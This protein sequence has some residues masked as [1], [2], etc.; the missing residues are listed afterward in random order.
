MKQKNKKR[1]IIIVGAGV[2][3][4][5]RMVTDLLFQFNAKSVAD[6][7]V[8]VDKFEREEKQDV[9]FAHM[10]LHDPL[11]G[12]SALKP[13]RTQ[14]NIVVLEADDYMSQKDR[15]RIALV[16]FSDIK[17]HKRIEEAALKLEISTRHLSEEMSA[18]KS[19]ILERPSVNPLDRQTRSKKSKKHNKYRR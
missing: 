1:G 7:I 17:Q 12:L 4:V 9:H 6:F 11:I 14:E 5:M 15:P 16:D 8:A 3:E 19:V 2:P 10:P 18:E 13:L